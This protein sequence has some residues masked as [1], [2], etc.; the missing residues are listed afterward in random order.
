MTKGNTT[1]LWNHLNTAHQ[2]KEGKLLKRKRLNSE[3][4]P[5]YCAKFSFKDLDT[6]EDIT[7][8]HGS[9][10]AIITRLVALDGDTFYNL[11]NSADKRKMI[12]GLGLGTL[13]SSP[14]GI[15]DLVL[16]FVGKNTTIL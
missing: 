3:L 5:A 1:G 7:I 11:A 4:S 8:D 10:E 12:H 6:G 14:T 15:R 13:P 9:L 2:I 16:R